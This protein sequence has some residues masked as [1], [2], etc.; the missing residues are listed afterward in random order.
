MS[1]NIDKIYYINLNHRTDRRDNIEREL[2]EFGL[3]YERFEAI[4]TPGVGIYGCGLSHLAVLKLAKANNYKNVLIMEDDFTFIVS[5]D[6]F[7]QQ[8]SSFF[9]LNIPFDVLMISYNAVE[10]ENTEYE[11]INKLKFSTTASGYIVAQHY[12]DKLIE[13]YEHAM[14]LLIQTREHWNYANDI[15]WRNL[16]AADTW[17]YFNKRIGKQASGYSDNSERHVDYDV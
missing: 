6:E 15:V 4:E 10:F 9:D 12:Y 16:Q 11:I 2:N 14:P 3:K 8:L 17:Y 7:E 5:K 13:L 1:Q